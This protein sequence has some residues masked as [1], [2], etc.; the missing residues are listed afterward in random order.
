[1]RRASWC[2]GYIF[3]F[4]CHNTSPRKHENELQIAKISEQFLQSVCWFLKRRSQIL[5]TAFFHRTFAAEICLDSGSIKKTT[6][7]VKCQSPWKTWSGFWTL[8]QM[9]RRW[10]GYRVKDHFFWKWWVVDIFLPCF[11]GDIYQEHTYL[12]FM[13]LWFMHHFFP[14]WVFSSNKLVEIQADGFAIPYAE[15][16]STYQSNVYW[17]AAHCLN[18]CRPNVGNEIL[19]SEILNYPFSDFKFFLGGS[20]FFR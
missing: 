13:H 4:S 5:E 2:A 10:L 3:W 14:P 19:H 1:M 11:N 7:E 17:E 6:V 12:N 9:L 15:W 18:W 20:I 8:I 16:P